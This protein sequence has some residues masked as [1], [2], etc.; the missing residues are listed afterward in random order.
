[1]YSDYDELDANHLAHHREIERCLH[2]DVERGA[3]NVGGH[4]AAPTRIHCL[5]LNRRLT[6]WLEKRAQGTS[7][8]HKGL[9]RLCYGKLDPQQNQIKE[10]E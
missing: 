7:Y 4:T 3:E 1:M 10:I 9:G 2:A 5:E 6:R 8:P